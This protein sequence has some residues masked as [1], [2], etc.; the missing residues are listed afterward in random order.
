MLLFRMTVLILSLGLTLAACSSGDE[1]KTNPFKGYKCMSGSFVLKFNTNT[2][3]YF[4]AI[5]YEATVY[6]GTYTYSGDTAT[7]VVTERTNRADDF[8][9]ILNPGNTIIFRRGPIRAE[10][11]DPL[12][13]GPWTVAPDW[14]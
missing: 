9:G 13:Q 2:T 1:E 12:M 6:R 14:A 7:L 11:N 4:Y 8:G 3:W 10:T 5:G